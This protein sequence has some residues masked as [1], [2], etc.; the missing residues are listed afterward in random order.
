MS[1]DYALLGQLFDDLRSVST[2]TERFSYYTRCVDALG[3]DG[4]TYTYV[5][6]VSLSTLAHFPPVFLRTDD[7]PIGFLEHYAA[8]RLDQ[9]DFTIRKVKSNDL[10]PM[11]WRE[12]E[13]SGLVSEK[14]SAVIALAREDYGIRNALSIPTMLWTAGGSGVS[15][16]SHERDEVFAKL[17]RERLETLVRCSQAFHDVSFSSAELPRVFIRPFRDSLKPKE[18]QILN[19]LA[20]GKHLKTIGQGISYQY[21]ARVLDELRARMGGITKDRLMYLVGQLNLLD[22]GDEA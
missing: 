11:D 5:P 13:L 9:Y 12:H 4:V 14:E 7:Y 10:S 22:D 21:A 2:L 1:V 19:H 8:E 15:V 6:N 18:L 16:I 3:F 20:N 17:K